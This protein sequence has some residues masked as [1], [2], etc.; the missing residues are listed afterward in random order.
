MKAAKRSL[1]AEIHHKFA[2]MLLK[3]I[4]TSIEEEVPLTAADK[5]IIMNFL[6]H[7][8]ITA[9]DDNNAMQNLKDSMDCEDELSKLRKERKKKL[10]TKL[11]QDGHDLAG[12]I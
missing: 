1:L 10:N 3:E 8:D 5:G 9:D 12:I 7:N 11:D 2:E 6:R 4:N